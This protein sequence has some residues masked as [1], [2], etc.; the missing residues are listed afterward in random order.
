MKKL[1]HILMDA[2]QKQKDQV[3]LTNP[4]STF[5]KKSG[6]WGV[7]KESSAFAE[8]CILKRSEIQIDIF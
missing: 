2:I 8:F 6:K 7:E 1:A 3:E 4:F 5:V